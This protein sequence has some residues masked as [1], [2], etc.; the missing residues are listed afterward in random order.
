MKGAIVYNGFWNREGLS[1]PVLRLQEAAEKRHISLMAIPNTLLTAAFGHDGP[2]VVGMPAADFVLFW[3]KDVRLARALE[4]CG[5]CVFNRADAIALCDDKAATH[6]MLAREGIPMLDT[7]VAPMTYLKMDE[8]GKA[9]LTRAEKRFGFPMVVKECYGSL[10]GQVYLA[11]NMEELYALMDQMAAR[12]FIIQEFVSASAGRDIRLYMAGGKLIAAMRRT[13]TSDFRA[14]I[15]NGGRAEAYAP[16]NEE[17]QLAERC[18]GLLGLDFAGVDLLHDAEGRPLVCEVN[19]NAHMA[20][21]TAC[22]G[23]D[24]AGGILDHVLSVLKETH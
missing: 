4:A 1:D 20:A 5:F 12:P 13:S 21:L 3:D 16:S 17:I 22:S 8:P 10:G 19:S 9:F 18:C 15:G 24:V 14:N 6:L 7:M 11:R 23:V 2:A